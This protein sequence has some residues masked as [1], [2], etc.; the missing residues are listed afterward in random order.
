[1]SG[2]GAVWLVTTRELTARGRSKTY[3]L[4]T[5]LVVVAIV[6][7]IVIPTLF[8][9]GAEVYEVA[10]VGSDSREIVEA[11]GELAAQRAGDD[12]EADVFTAVEFADEQAASAALAAGE[13]TAVVVDGDRLIVDGV[14]AF[15]PPAVAAPLQEAAGT[16]RIEALLARDDG[17]GE[18]LAI[19]ASEPL[20]L[21]QLDGAAE[22][23]DVV[24]A[25]VAAGGMILMYFAILM[26][27]NW[28]LSAVA[29]EKTSRVVEVLLSTFR[30]WQIFAGKLLGIGLLGLGQLL[31]VVVA[32]V[33]AFVATNDVDVPR[34]PIDSV[35]ALVGWF[36]IGFLLY[37]SL[38]G[39][40]GALVSR[41][42]DAQS[43]AAPMSIVAVLGYFVSFATFDDP[44]G[45]LAVAATLF[46]FTAPFV[47]PI[48]LALD[49]I[50]GWEMALAV[51]LSV[52]TIVVSVR[53][54]GRI[55]A[56]G[57]LRSGS[58]VGWREALR[59]ER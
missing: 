59:S 51:A 54:G 2:A 27:G 40:A 28:M 30:P 14:S 26:Y 44:E 16:I 31:L 19:L 52:A 33:V 1:M 25:A 20:E 57:I 21:E 48:R 39:S 3:L 42:E 6:A 8:G 15:G 35:V 58:R 49:A 7:A 45:P 46:P 37:A 24:R 18:V 43:V 29:E 12:E 38:F 5:A 4:M 10:V 55:Y 50:A 47:A 36:V 11:A 53:I 32:A 22:E 13:V 9:G 41:T 17:A 23:P 34:L 56:G